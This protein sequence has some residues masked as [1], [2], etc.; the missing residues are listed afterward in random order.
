MQSTRTI[1]CA[2]LVTREDGMNLRKR[3][4]THGSTCRK[5]NGALAVPPASIG[6]SPWEHMQACPL[7]I[8]NPPLVRASAATILE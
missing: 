7:R 3:L 2:R 6:R 8:G 1:S 4:A 5:K